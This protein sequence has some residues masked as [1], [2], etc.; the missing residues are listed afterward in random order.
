MRDSHQIT[1]DGAASENGSSDA[2]EIVRLREVVA[3]LEKE[4]AQLET[5]LQSRILLEQAKGVLAE[6][7]EIAV[8]EAFVLLRRAARSNRV[9]LRLVAAAGDDRVLAGQVEERRRGHPLSLWEPGVPG[10]SRRRGAC[11]R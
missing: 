4:R 9:Q 5:A 1:G 2:R 3:L 7:L 6:R 10:R 11:A 8:D